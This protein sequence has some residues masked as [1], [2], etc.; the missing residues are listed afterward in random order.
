MTRAMDLSRMKYLI[1]GLCVLGLAVDI[2]E[3][4][5]R[6]RDC[7]PE[8]SCYRR[9]VDCIKRGLQYI[10]VNI[11]VNT[12]RLNLDGNNITKIRKGDF[13]NLRRLRVLQLSNNQIVSIERGAFSDLRSVERM[14]L[15][16][17]Q[18]QSLPELVFSN[19]DS[20]YRLDLSNNKLMLISRK[21]F[22]GT[23]LLRNL[24][25]EYNQITCI[26]DGAFRPLRMLERLSLSNNNLT[27]LSSS[28]FTH[29]TYLKT[30]RLA[31]ND[32][33]CDCYLGWFASW[34]RLHPRLALS[35]RCSHPRQFRGL[36]IP[37][38]QVGDFRCSGEEDHEV[39]CKVKPLCPAGCACNSENVVDCR[40]IGLTEL[41]TTFPDRAVELRLEQNQIRSIPSR[42]FTQYKKLKR[43]D[44]SNNMIET[45]AD[46]A[47]TGLR[48]LSSLVLYGNQIADLPE[49]I[50]RG[51]TSLQLLLLNAN[52]ISC[53]RVNLFQDLISLNLLSLYD[54][55]I[56]SLAN[57]TLAPLRNL[58]TMHL[59]RNPLICDCNLKWLVEYLQGNPVEKSGAR[60]ET[61]RRM[62]GKRLNRMKSIK[63][64]C[65]D[66]EYQRTMHAGECF[67]DSD[68][69]ESCSCSGTI[70]DCSNRG[71]HSVPDSIPTYTTELLLND[72]DISRIS[73]GGKF[74]NLINLNKLDL[75]NNRISIIE[76]GAFEGAENLFELNLRSNRLTCIG[77]ETFIGLRSLRLLALYDNG[78]S[79]ITS[80]AFDSLKEL[81]TVNLM[82]NPLNCNCHL[83]WLPEW[84]ISRNIVTGNPICQS[85]D[86]LRDVP[87][88]ALEK[89]DFSCEEND[90]NSCL[91]SVACPRECACSGS[92]VRCS[93]KE[94]TMPPRNIPLTATEIYL[95]SNQL[96]TIPDGMT[97]L[98]SLHTL[99][100]STN[101]ITMLP[102][103]AF[104]NMTKLSTLILSYNR[105]AC[106]PPGTFTGLRSLRILSL[107]GNDLSTLP[108]GVFSD[109]HS[110]SHI[111]LGNNPLYCDCNLQWLSE[112]VKADGFK[113]PGIAKC[114][115]PYDLRGKLILTA[116]SRSFI[117]TEEPDM[118]ILAKCNPC[119]SGPCQN[120]GACSVSL[121]ERYTC[122]CPEGFKGR[123]CEVELD[124]CEGMPCLNGGQ[125]QNLNGGFRC[126]CM[127]GFE[128]DLCESNID[129]CKHHQCL[130]D[131]ICQDGI[132]N[133]TCYCSLGYSGTY[134]EVDKDLCASGANPCQNGG[135]CYDLGRSYRCECPPSY[136]GLNCTESYQDC[137]NEG[138]QNEGQ[139]IQEMDQFVCRCPQGFSGVRCE[140]VPIVF[141][142]ASPC[143][144][145]DCQNQALCQVEAGGEVHCLCRPGYVGKRCEVSTS[146]TFSQQSA[147]L[148]VNPLDMSSP[149]NFT[150]SFATAQENGILLYHGGAGTVDHLAVELFRGYLR[151]SY[152]AG[153]FPATTVFSQHNLNDGEFHTVRVL[154]SGRNISLQID[155]EEVQSATNEGPST[156]LNVNAPLFIGG[157]PSKKNAYALRHRHLRN[158]SSFQGCLQGFF[159][160]DEP[161]TPMEGE[162]LGVTTG[163]PALDMPDPCQTNPCKQGFCRKLDSAR[164]TCDCQD[165]WMGPMCD[166]RTTC[167]GQ[168]HQVTVERGTCRSANPIKTMDCGGECGGASCCRPQ[169]VRTRLVL[170]QCEDGTE[171]KEEVKIVR[172]CACQECVETPEIVNEPE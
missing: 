91:P 107:Q 49:G 24:N 47:F 55:Q 133:Y 149:I 121:T 1:A 92:V 129:D 170:L 2:S 163:C 72:N 155:D 45:I 101:L 131:G 29:M 78:I 85:P 58:Q 87:L 158:G 144:F 42:A 15:D 32:L 18:L 116:P 27:T 68:C 123:N 4:G 99:D 136:R 14:R 100:L 19:M 63:F 30:L 146:L 88:E 147:L 125:C 83:S 94:L 7:P 103:N 23:G 69:P 164:Y 140:D 64:K 10:P 106:I 46:D 50:F 130:N 33:Y 90:L 89:T 37:E 93:R 115:D 34:L 8:C 134:C 152:I 28:S 141:P 16:G 112:W 169:R 80:G 145:H 57:G 25:L 9:T 54:N 86:N 71:F 120:Q 157:A 66:A 108:N 124:A 122:S 82:G 17:N 118:N 31:G 95:D 154:V 110:L 159:I 153:N 162:V 56:M 62:E 3:G 135:V 44:L 39:M 148:K 61:P 142:Q 96:V 166:R 105:I 21:L 161:V 73:A 48:S 137:R 167:T 74:L 132:N 36:K 6:A 127:P 81:S 113:E 156:Y 5:R 53:I 84:L 51:L 41:P 40:G 38:L 151:V 150:V 97:N 138:C 168:P 60:C 128:G 75:R 70:V 109:L 117:C 77:N 26:I 139:C 165:G 114:A 11:P 12:E 20:L 102:E 13:D 43:I 76:E 171:V 104:A 98:K 22:R 35:T 126:E 160:N 65:K 119:L 143:D 172:S 79:T 67:I 52:H 111:A 59:A